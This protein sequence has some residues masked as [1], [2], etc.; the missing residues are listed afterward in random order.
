MSEKP[1]EAEQ[2][3]QRIARELAALRQRGLSALSISTHNQAAAELAE[4]IPLA[5]AHA[6]RLDR[7]WDERGSVKRLLLD[8]LAAFGSEPEYEDDA[9]LIYSLFF[10]KDSDR[11]APGELLRQARDR[12]NVERTKFRTDYQNPAFL[13][14]ARFLVGWIDRKAA[15]RDQRGVDTAGELGQAALTFSRNDLTS[16]FETLVR[17]EN[18]SDIAKL[19]ALVGRL[20]SSHELIPLVEIMR[21]RS[22]H[23]QVD[24]ILREA[25]ASMDIYGLIDLVELFYK[26]GWRLDTL[27]SAIA[28]FR[29]AEDVAVILSVIGDRKE[30]AEL[31]RQS[32]AVRAAAKEPEQQLPEL[33]DEVAS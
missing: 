9:G 12:L 23:E 24:A 22:L 6:E 28:A 19:A 7:L 31:K 29:S 11:V 32:E 8:V 1:G 27:I 18:R 2:R 17:D 21:R 5:Q 33:N 16:L 4:L 13:S 15:A 30:A 10:Y 14:F 26:E 3:A 20:Y 25:V